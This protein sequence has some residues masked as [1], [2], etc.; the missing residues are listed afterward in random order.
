MQVS[1][2]SITGRLPT[3]TR[4]ISSRSAPI[5]FWKDAT[6]S[7]AASVVSFMEM[8]SWA[9]L[10][11][12]PNQLEI[13][14]NVKSV[15]GR[16]LVLGHHL[17]GDRAVFDVHLLV[18]FADEAALSGAVNHL[19]RCG[20][21]T[22]VD[23]GRRHVLGLALRRCLVALEIGIVSAAPAM[24]AAT[25]ALTGLV[26]RAALSAA[27]LAAGSRRLALTGAGDRDA[28]AAEPAPDHELLAALSAGLRPAPLL[29]AALIA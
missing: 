15:A 18:T 1:T 22:G 23:A 17:L 7:R 26:A 5:L 4:P 10:L 6:S 27:V 19:A 14:L 11:T 12:R 8:L 28:L 16:D 20:S 29:A 2:P 25:G 3:I 9:R 13:A 24:T 21:L